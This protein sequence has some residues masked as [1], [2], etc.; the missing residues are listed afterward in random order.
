MKIIKLL[1]FSLTILSISV[2]VFNNATQLVREI[3]IPTFNVGLWISFAM[4]VLGVVS[5][6]VLNYKYMK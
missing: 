5:Y 3:F 4:I 2:V 6:T 1:L